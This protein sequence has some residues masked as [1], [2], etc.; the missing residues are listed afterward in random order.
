MGA[1]QPALVG[2]DSDVVVSLGVELDRY[3]AGSDIGDGGPLPTDRT[4]RDVDVFTG[5]AVLFDAAFLDTTGGFDE[6]YFLYY[7]DVDLAL[8]GG[9]LGWRYRVAPEST[10]EHRRGTS[11]ASAPGRDAV[12]AGAQSAVGGLPLRLGRDH[13]PR[14]LAVGAAPETRTHV[15]ASPLTGRRPRRCAAPRVRAGPGRAAIQ[16]FGPSRNG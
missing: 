4:V 14:H 1:V 8:R 2:P 10:V 16:W 11:T 9:S 5:G 7:E 6:R 3:G 15:G 12:P 13:G